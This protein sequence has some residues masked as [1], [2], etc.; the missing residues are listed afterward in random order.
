MAFRTRQVA[1]DVPIL[2]LGTHKKGTLG[3]LAL[4]D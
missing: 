2:L 1:A 3:T 4:F